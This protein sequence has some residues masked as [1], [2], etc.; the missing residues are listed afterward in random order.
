M[1][2]AHA[3]IYSAVIGSPY[4]RVR[5]KLKLGNFYGEKPPQVHPTEIRTSISPSSTVELN[6]I[7]AL[8]NYAT[9]AGESTEL[10]NIVGLIVSYVYS[11]PTESERAINFARNYILTMGRMM[12]TWGLS[13]M[14]IDISTVKDV[15]QLDSRAAYA[16]N[17]R[18]SV[19]RLSRQSGLFINSSHTVLHR[20]LKIYP[21]KSVSSRNCCQETWK[22]LK[23]IVTDFNMFID[24]KEYE[25]FTSILVKNIAAS[26]HKQFRKHVEQ[27]STLTL[28]EWMLT[29]DQV[30]LPWP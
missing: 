27:E 21:T 14:S 4:K 1:S 20:T 23:L 2:L 24:S 16:A 25:C 22:D 29:L 6:T 10:A 3:H 5:R 9:E 18:K 19:H 17:H 30:K 13:P 28:N 26:A 15:A 11:D 12:S 8:A 7:S